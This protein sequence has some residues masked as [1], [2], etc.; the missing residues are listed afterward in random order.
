MLVR[1][2]SAAWARPTGCAQVANPGSTLV[3]HGGKN[4]LLPW[5]FVRAWWHAGRA[6]I[7]R[8]CDLV[9]TGDAVTYVALWPVLAALRVRTVTM[10]MGLDLT[11]PNRYYGIVARAL[12]P[13]AT[14]V[15]AIST[16][17]AAAARAV[18][19]ESDRCGI[20]R[21]AVVAPDCGP[22]DRAQPAAESS[23][24]SASPARGRAADRRATRRPRSPM[25]RGRVMP[26]LPPSV[27]YRRRFGPRPH[28]HRTVAAAGSPR[29]YTAR[30]RLGGRA[31]ETS[32]AA[33]TC[34]CSRTFRSGRHGG[35][36][37]VVLEA[38]TR[39]TPVVGA[40]QGL[41]DAVVDGKPASSSHRATPRRG[42]ARD[43]PRADRAGLVDVGARFRART[44][45]LDSWE[46]LQESL[47]AELAQSQRA[48]RSRT[49]RSIKP[50]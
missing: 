12:I 5:F 40:L 17:T 50:S 31:R 9:M 23:N 11:W 16:A 21:P 46:R 8:R 41:R 45:E 14:R 28:E 20:V 2:R 15:I 6:V 10:V 48:T 34:S 4:R 37:L 30:P 49:V 22:L 39:G 29:R 36:G 18:G 19:V 38:A 42:R 35:F 1:R 44:V 7:G 25:V 47:T 32:C 13:R 24:A 27:H 3:A 43:E 26:K 33:A